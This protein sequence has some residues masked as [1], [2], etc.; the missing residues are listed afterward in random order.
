MKLVLRSF[1]SIL[2]LLSAA[3]LVAS[4]CD[5]PC[6]TNSC[7]PT[8]TPCQYKCPN[9]C[10]EVFGKTFY[11][12]R[13][14]DSNVARRMVGVIDK[15][16]PYGKEEFS[17]MIN[18]GL[19]YT[20]SF[21]NHDLA[22]FLSFNDSTQM[23]YGPSCGAFDIYGL[24]FGT[25]GTNGIAFSSAGL[26][27]VTPEFGTGNGV[28]LRPKIQ[29]FI[30][31]LDFVG[32][33]DGYVCGLWT[34]LTL[35]VVRT[36][37]DLRVVESAGGV[38]ATGDYPTNAV[39]CGIDAG[40]PVVFP[41]L[42]SAWEN[43]GKF[44]SVPAGEFGKL[45]G[46]CNR[47]KTDLAGIHFEVGYDFHRSETGFFGLGVHVVAP[48]GT[49]PN[50]KLFFEPV[51]GAN[52]SWQLGVTAQGGYQLWQNCDGNQ[53]LAL[54]FD[55]IVTHLFASKQR[56]LFGLTINGA[57]SAGSSYL[58]LKRFNADGTLADDCL[59]RAS[60]LLA[61]E[62]KIK[63][64]VMADLAI[65]LQYDKCNWSTAVGY[66]F[67]L[68]TKEKLN[69]NLCSNPFNDPKFKYAIKGSTLAN[70]SE[71]Q[72]TATI[73][74]C[75]ETDAT[76]VFLTAADVDVCPALNSRTLSNKV[77]GF[78]GYN[79]KDC[80]YVPYILLEGEVEF[81][82]SNKT[83]DQWGVMLKGGVQF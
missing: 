28:C 33:W 10:G 76:P 4:S 52:R 45:S 65:M 7:E 1:F 55:S 24:N 23:T 43:L 44:G 47:Q 30:A 61:L 19:Q 67:W 77:F 3:S 63:A 54:Y 62:S 40:T 79:W 75:G 70:N 14:Q 36:K 56:R 69:G 39:T 12:A 9:E 81:G 71:T 35:P 34:R 48:T 31:E 64:D 17:G 51:V 21:E 72:S 16:H 82:N 41:N 2:L 73:G 68:R 42:A 57:S 58:L 66:N 59:E 78:V 26:S 6:K 83:V 5:T 38:A 37:Y 80:E 13:P 53:S 18:V 20:Q 46:S 74:N 8:T 25:T 60:N 27:D 32:N 50:A 29:N 15:T 11:S 49:R 22:R